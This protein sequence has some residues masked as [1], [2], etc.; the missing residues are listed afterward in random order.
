M[1]LSDMNLKC[2]EPL[3]TKCSVID[4]TDLQF[5]AEF[6][7]DMAYGKSR[8]KHIAYESRISKLC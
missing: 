1:S 5:S 4:K 6:N 2:L 3:R 7:H 8:G